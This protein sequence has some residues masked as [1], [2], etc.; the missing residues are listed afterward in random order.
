MTSLQTNE[1]SNNSVHPEQ[2]QPVDTLIE[3]Y[4]VKHFREAEC[5]PGLSFRQGGRDMLQI[6]VPASHVPILLEAKPS[7][8]TKNNPHSGKNRPRVK[9][10]AEEIRDYVVDRAKAR[11]PWILGTLTAN[12]SRDK[13]DIIDF[14]KG[15][16]L[17][18][19]PKGVSLDITDGQHRTFAI[20]ELRQSSERS[21]IS[22]DS[23]PIT[24]V[25]EDDFR[26][27]QTDFRDM[28][29]TKP[30]SKAQLV[31]FGDLG[32][33]GI[34]QEL[35]ERVPMFHDKTQKI[36]AS[37]GSGTKFIYTSNYIAKAVSYAFANDSSDELLNR[38]SKQ[39]AEVLVQCFNQFFSECFDTKYIFEKKVEELTV[40]EVSAFREDCLLGVSV[41][42]EILGRLLYCTYDDDSNAFD[43]VMVSKIAKLDWSRESDLWKNNVVRQD[44]NPKEPTKP[45]KITASG[46][47]VRIAVEAAKTQLGWK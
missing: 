7:D 20:Q 29:Q 36:K 15:V 44:P 12:V 28:A 47:N 9:G 8:A 13:I 21:S 10:H 6:N 17:V 27:C 26:Q 30:I 25:L 35:V 1:A 40:D 4:I 39:S 31:S 32:R 34:T 43:E 45:Y 18:I 33:D 11:K 19:I 3:P 41:G 5:Y 16:C 24:L 23:F 38:D 37:P 46:S 22:E 14:G 2:K 42:L